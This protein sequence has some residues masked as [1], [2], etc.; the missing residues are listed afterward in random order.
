MRAYSLVVAAADA[1]GK[2]KRTEAAEFRSLEATQI[3]EEVQKSK[4]ALF[5]LRV[6]QKTKQVRFLLDW[7]TFQGRCFLFC[8]SQHDELLFAFHF[9]IGLE[10][11]MYGD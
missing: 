6:A 11:S 5:D 3:D 10:I 4:R 8:M 9:R 1:D 2:K 7:K